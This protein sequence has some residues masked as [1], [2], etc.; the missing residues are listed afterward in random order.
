MIAAVEPSSHP[1]GTPWIERKR[2][3]DG[4]ERRY[5]CELEYASPPLVVVRFVMRQ[6]GEVF[7]TPIA[8][9]AGAVSFGYFWRSR[10]YTVYRMR[11]EAGVIAHRFDAVANI[12][13]GN[14]EVAYRDLA[15]DWWL[16]PGGELI[17]EDREEFDALRAVAAFSPAELRAVARAERVIAGAGRRLLPELASLERQLRIA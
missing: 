1:R 13:I 16:M 12:R 2:K 9:P 3:L 14:G 5:R 8:I 17:E 6:G 10:P 7:G 4:S 15:L 11:S